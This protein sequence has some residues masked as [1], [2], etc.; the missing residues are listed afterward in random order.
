[1][2]WAA[3]FIIVERVEDLLLEGGGEVERASEK[4]GD[5]WGEGR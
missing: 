1:M 3:S 5:E 4:D 2:I